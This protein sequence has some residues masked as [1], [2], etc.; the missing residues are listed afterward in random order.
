MN[1]RGS[2]QKPQAEIKKCANFFVFVLH[3]VSMTVGD[4]GQRVKS[5]LKQN[6]KIFFTN[7]IGMTTFK[8]WCVNKMRYLIHGHKELWH[9]I[10]LG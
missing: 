5:R 2:L 8:N 1:I 9:N 4:S 7:K 3:F 10:I 6:E